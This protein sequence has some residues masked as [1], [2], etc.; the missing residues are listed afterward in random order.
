MVM[1]TNTGRAGLVRFLAGAAAAIALAVVTACGSAGSPP[2]NNVK[3]LAGQ[4]ANTHP[5]GSFSTVQVLAT[6]AVGNYLVR[7]TGQANV[8][9]NVALIL[10]SRAC[11]PTLAA[12]RH[13]LQ[14]GDRPARRGL[15]ATGPYNWPQSAGTISFTR[16]IAVPVGSGPGNVCVYMD[17][18]SRPDSSPPLDTVFKRVTLTS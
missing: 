10:D 16:Q 2:P 12:E 9:T 5:S 4:G 15:T 3:G 7:I 13:K 1:R 6:R 8:G 11:A 14:V 18:A 17:A